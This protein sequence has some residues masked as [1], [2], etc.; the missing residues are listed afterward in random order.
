MYTLKPIIP[1]L[2]SHLA[3]R[4]WIKFTIFNKF[5]ALVAVELKSKFNQFWRALVS[6]CALS[7][8][9]LALVF[10]QIEIQLSL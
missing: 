2:L 3:S 7:V 10:E 4:S 1:L 9:V 6:L 8:C 5:S